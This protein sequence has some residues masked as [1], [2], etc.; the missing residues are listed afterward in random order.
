M[1]KQQ[2]LLTAAVMVVLLLLLGCPSPNSE[3]SQTYENVKSLFI[4]NTSKTNKEPSD[5]WLSISTTS[6]SLIPQEINSATANAPVNRVFRTPTFNP[7]NYKIPEARSAGKQMPEKKYKVGDTK[8]LQNTFDKYLLEQK[9]FKC[10]YEGEYCYIWLCEVEKNNPD[11]YLT[12]EEIQFY[13]KKFDE[14]Y[15][16]ETAICGPKYN[17]YSEEVDNLIRPNPKISI[18]FEDIDGD[19]EV[20]YYGGYFT[21][22]DMLT[23]S[24]DSGNNQ[25]EAIHIDSYYAKQE[26][27]RGRVCSF[28]VHEFNH[29]LNFDNKFIKYNKSMDLWF[30]EMLSLTLEDLFYEEFGLTAIESSPSR[31]YLFSQ[32][33]Y[34]YGFKNW[35]QRKDPAEEMADYSNVYAFGAFLTRN[36]GGPELVHEIATNEYVNEEAVVKAIEKVTGQKKTFAGLLAEF[37]TV[38]INLDGENSDLPSLN[39]TVTGKAGDYDFKLNALSLKAFEEATGEKYDIITT[40]LRENYF[41][42]HA[43]GFLYFTFEKPTTVSLNISEDAKDYITIVAK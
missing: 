14:I 15:V 3:A 19:G 32:G 43:Y 6:R 35:I 16:K 22:S 21:N 4:V 41:K 1:K 40:S 42:L 24:G 28:I 2:I 13:A 8:A 5:K 29:K 30:T 34:Y 31:L 36:Y 39:K 12:E 26:D 17:G 18:I 23:Y 25:I 20:A 7:D 33:N 38:L 9:R 37:P 11:L 10:V 27:L